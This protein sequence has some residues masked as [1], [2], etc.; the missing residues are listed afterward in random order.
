MAK[1]LLEDKVCLITGASR[2]IGRAI[3]EQ[4]V[5]EGAI[6]YANARKDGDLDDWARELKQ[7]YGAEVFLVYFD[8]TDYTAVKDIVKNIK[9]QHG[10][11][12]VLV[13][14]AGIVAYEAL[15]MIDFDYFREMFEVNVVATTNLI[16]LVS[17][18][19]VRQKS[20]SIINMSSIVAEKGV[21]G[22][23]AYSATKG[24]V[25]S[26]TKSASKELAA[27]NIR[28][29]AVAP[30]MVGTERLKKVFENNLDEKLQSVGMKRMGNPKEIADTFVYLA[31]DMSTYVTGQIIVVDG[32]TQM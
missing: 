24:A 9:K 8:I 16:Q 18:L 11:I 22:Q 17:R 29:N 14:N 32:S 25:S 21:K 28:V 3:A 20:G 19:M 1:K 31:S 23:L 5:H 13:N 6:V 12:D 30:G 7:T 4:Y 2:G 26:L 27:H 15:G 10:R